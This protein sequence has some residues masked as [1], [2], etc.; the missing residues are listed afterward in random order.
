MAFW[1]I[2]QLMAHLVGY[3]I[4][5]LDLVTSLSDLFEEEVVT[6]SGETVN[7]WI[8]NQGGWVSI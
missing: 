5:F 6:K 3:K 1:Q 2:L 7:K 8:A 4:R